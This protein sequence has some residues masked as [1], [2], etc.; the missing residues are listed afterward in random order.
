MASETQIVAHGAWDDDVEGQL[1]VPDQVYRRR[2]QPVSHSDT[3]LATQSDHHLDPVIQET[4]RPQTYSLA[5]WINPITVIRAATHIWR[6]R[7][8]IARPSLH[9]SHEP[10]PPMS[11]RTK[12]F[13]RDSNGVVQER[14]QVEMRRNPIK[15]LKNAGQRLFICVDHGRR[16]QFAIQMLCLRPTRHRRVLGSVKT[17]DKN[18]Q[19]VIK[20][21]LE[22]LSRTEQAC[23]SDG[24]IVERIQRRL[25]RDLG[26]LVRLTP[27][28]GVVDAEIVEVSF[29]RVS[30]YFETVEAHSD[31]KA[32]S[33][34]FIDTLDNA[35]CRSQSMNERTGHPLR[36]RLG[37]TT[38]MLCSTGR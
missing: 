9:T 16:G 35:T 28:Y 11:E 38:R 33:G 19:P 8:R 7:S 3:R 12:D 22:K 32:S 23:E 5:R 21:M 1:R 26:T 27:Y 20:P 4:L 25:R 17:T 15:R 10:H 37:K 6:L 13:N 18:G 31:T 30:I 34:F 2:N 36:R 24:A 29:R 14:L